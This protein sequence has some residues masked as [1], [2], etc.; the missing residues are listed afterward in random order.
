M[1]SVLIDNSTLTAVQRLI[2]DVPVARSFPIEGDL[3]AFDQYLQS[4]LLYD[5]IA[6]VDD[7][8]EEHRVGRSKSFK[9]V[10]FLDPLKLPYQS[11]IDEAADQL[12]RVAFQIQK[13]AVKQGP[14][15]D[16]LRSLD[17][18]VAPA[19]Y[20]QSSDWFL[21]LRLMA[22]EADIHLPKYGIL[23]TTIKDQARENEKSFD[24]F[25]PQFRIEDRQGNRIDLDKTGD[26]SVDEDLKKFA[27][28]LNWIGHRSV[29]YH[30]LSNNLKCALSLHPIRHQYIAQYILSQSPDY[31]KPNLRSDVLEFFQSG[32][33][34]IRDASD[35][36]LGLG[37][38]QTSLPFF[39]AWAVGY[40]GNPRN[41]YDH[42]LQIRYSPAAV[43]LRTH[44][45]E[46]DELL[47]GNDIEKAR[48]SVAKLRSAVADDFNK[49]AVKFE[50][51]KPNPGLGIS[52]NA[53]TLSPSIS[54]PSVY[55]RVK[56]LLPSHAK[57][58]ALVLR[59][60]SDEIMKTST[61]GALSDQFSLSRR[62]HKGTGYVSDRTRTEL[63]RYKNSHSSIK[64]PL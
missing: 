7:Y 59:N 51:R 44:F 12:S 16:L 1:L 9:E 39:A 5:E 41:G 10:R 29:F 37:A 28:S 2:G 48:V 61:F 4:L 6:A 30:N 21:H 17:L 18:H 45:R 36:M 49:L 42:V 24:K 26:G 62:Y 47:N 58:A 33:S 11:S 23:M 56:S 14:L 55:E 50:G 54:I 15:N 31:T 19:W 53:L 40:A 52:I 25:K 8:K 63:T 22:D 3:S 27:S 35:T 34:K 38:F 13:G 60:I 32:M 46:I 43:Q 20:M 64:R 57:N